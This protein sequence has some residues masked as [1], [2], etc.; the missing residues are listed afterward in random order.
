MN[1]LKSL[2][3]TKWRFLNKFKIELLYDPAIPLLVIHPKKLNYCFQEIPA[4]QV[5][6]SII[7]NSQDIETT[8]MDG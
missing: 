6:C 3:K 2:W 1:K 8:Q 7:Y 4:S 5:Y